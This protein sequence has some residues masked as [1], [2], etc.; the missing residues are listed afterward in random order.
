MRRWKIGVTMLVV[1]IGVLAMTVVSGE[2]KKKKAEGAAWGV[3]TQLSGKQEIGADGHKRA[4][5]PDGYG[6]FAATS[7]GDQ[8]CFGLAVAAIGDPA[9]AHIRQAKRNKNGPVVVTLTPPSS[10]NPGSSS[11]CTTVDTNLLAA[12]RKHP[13]RYYVNVHNSDY[14][15]GAIRGQLRKPKK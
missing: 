2:A 15:G 7:Q 5:D 6:V 14:P 10:G 9:A 8:L 13:K 4:G 1:L 3:T 12:I 11:A